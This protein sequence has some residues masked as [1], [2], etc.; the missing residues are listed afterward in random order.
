M[1][2]ISVEQWSLKAFQVH[3]GFVAGKFKAVTFQSYCRLE[4][5]VRGL[6]S[7]SLSKQTQVYKNITWLKSLSWGGAG[8]MGF[9]LPP[10]YRLCLVKALSWLCYVSLI[11]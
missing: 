3:V 1:W 10:L 2:E 11:P 7:R 9:L 4:P 5:S 6:G 8:A